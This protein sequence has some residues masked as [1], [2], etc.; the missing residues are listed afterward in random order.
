[1]LLLLLLLL[2]LLNRSNKSS[3]PINEFIFWVGTWEAV[4]EGMGSP[5]DN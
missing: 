4:V 2:L 1:M 3:F 5:A